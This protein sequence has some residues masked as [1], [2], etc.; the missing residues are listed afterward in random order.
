MPAAFYGAEIVY[1]G[2]SHFD[3]LRT[4]IAQALVGETA[5]SMNPAI[6]LHCAD[7]SAL[8][9][10][11]YVILQAIKQAKLYL[12]RASANDQKRFLQVLATPTKNSRDVKGPASALREYLLIIGWT[13]ST[14]GDIQLS[15]YKSGNIMTSPFSV[16]KRHAMQAWQ[17]HLLMLFTERHKLFTFPPIDKLSVC[18][19][20]RQFNEKQQLMILREV[21][22]AFQTKHQQSQWDPTTC[23]TCD[24]CGADEDTRQHRILRCL[25][26]S[27]IREKF[28]DVT[29]FL[30]DEGNDWCELAVVARHPMQDFYESVNDAMPEISIQEEIKQILQRGRTADN[31]FFY[32]DGSCQH[33]RYPLTRYAALSIIVDTAEDDIERRYQANQYVSTRAWPCT[34]QRIAWGHLPGV[35]AIHRAE[36]LAVV[37]LCE[38]FSAF[39]VFTDCAFVLTMVDMCRD[40]T[41]KL[42]IFQHDD[43]DLLLRL[44]NSI[45]DE[46][47]IVKIKAHQDLLNIRDSLDRI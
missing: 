25:A 14:N 16:L 28:P 41:M 30:E 7:P 12:F 9:P 13:C 39:T 20:L 43:Y 26:F 3:S 44:Y 2:Q 24:F 31:L 11:L 1:I 23:T 47:K 6:F 38:N 46:K 10:Q 19:V 27:E 35:Q 34:F 21:A 36:L 18:Q 15:Q 5:K 17:E 29:A 45:I 37:I 33:S 8:D 4:A 42:K 32:T 22:G 40:P